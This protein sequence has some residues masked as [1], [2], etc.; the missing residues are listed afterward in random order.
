MG[1][2]LTGNRYILQ[3]PVLAQIASLTTVRIALALFYAFAP[4]PPGWRPVTPAHL[5]LVTPAHLFP[6]TPATRQFFGTTPMVHVLQKLNYKYKNKKS[7][8]YIYN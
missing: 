3:T 7:N 6:V 1:N 2:R 4:S 8:I 5:F